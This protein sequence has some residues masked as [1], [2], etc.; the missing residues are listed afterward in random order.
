MGQ[1][2]ADW[3]RGEGDG[4]DTIHREEGTR[5]DARATSPKGARARAYFP[6]S[7]TLGTRGMA[8]NVDVAAMCLLLIF[9]RYFL[10]RLRFAVT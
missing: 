9:L 10:S 1:A 5:G 4:K 3:G 7:R 8:R 6:C 2:N